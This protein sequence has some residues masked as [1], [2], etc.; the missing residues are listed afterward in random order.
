VSEALVWPTGRSFTRAHS[1]EFGSTEFDGRT[2]V[3]ARF[4]PLYVTDEVTPVMYAGAGD[5]TAAAE[6]VFRRLPDRGRPRRVWLD[7]YRAWHWSQVHPR[8]DLLLLPLDAG[9]PEAGLLV[10]GDAATYPT[11]R[12]EAARLLR[13]HQGLD[14][15]IWVSRQLHD[16]PSTVTLDLGMPAV[17]L[18]L[19]APMRARTGGVRRDELTS[20]HPVV[21]FATPA[22]LERLDLIAD[23]LDVTVVRT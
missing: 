12:R 18:L 23:Q 20:A 10:D 1:H 22:G 2:D 8:R 4:S 13:T 11:A 5:A 14:G 7:R 6:T 19:V 15:L 9:L 3:D 16:R 17:C 21:P